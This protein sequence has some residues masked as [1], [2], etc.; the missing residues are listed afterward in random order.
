MIIY[1]F[2][3]LSQTVINIREIILKCECEFSSLFSL[4]VHA[5]SDA[6]IS[7]E[8]VLKLAD[9]IMIV[10]PPDKL[11]KNVDYELKKVIEKGSIQSFLTPKHLKMKSVQ[12]DWILLR[13]KNCRRCSNIV[14][15]QKNIIPS[16]EMKARNTQILNSKIDINKNNKFKWFTDINQKFIYYLFKNL[17]NSNMRKML[18][19]NS[20]LIEK[21][22]SYI[23]PSREYSAELNY[24]I[25]FSL[26]DLNKYLSGDKRIENSNFDF[27]LSRWVENLQ[28]LDENLHSIKYLFVLTAVLAGV[29]GTSVYCY[30]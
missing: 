17:K 10:I 25:F 7:F 14:I 16:S 1:L 28:N 27:V 23:G 11:K 3:F 24:G 21:R 9:N 6:N 19:K 13:N 26:N 15:R 5:P 4:L 29:L 8:K 30:L 12:P 18:R 22:Y 2:L 20:A